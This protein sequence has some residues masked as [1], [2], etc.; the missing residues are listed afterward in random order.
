VPPVDV[1]AGLRNFAES[2]W[3]SWPVEE[4]LRAR[5]VD[6]DRLRRINFAGLDDFLG[7]RVTPAELSSLVDTINSE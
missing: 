7:A 3:Q 5:G 4:N 6:V 1:A 2:V